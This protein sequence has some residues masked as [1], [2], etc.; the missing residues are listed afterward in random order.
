MDYPITVEREVAGRVRV[1]FP[2]FPGAHAMGS[3]EA[4]GL[5]HAQEALAS[6]VERHIK[7]RRAVPSPSAV[8]THYV[9]VPALIEVK[10]R[11]YD[12]MRAANIGKAELARRLHWHMPQV[13]RLFDV[14][15]GSRLEQLES[16]FAAL[17]KRLV[18]DVQDEGVSPES[19]RH[20]GRTAARA[21]VA[22]PAHTGTPAFEVQW[23]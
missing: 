4:E 5:R 21:G 7:E 13:D 9:T 18:V 6:A 19:T 2:D 14:R 1:A 22:R 16:A 8:T 11:L 12:A 20:G 3:D 10:I 15:H 23:D 17:G